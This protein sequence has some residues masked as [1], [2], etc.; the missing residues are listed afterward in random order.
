MN[1]VV[2]ANIR[3][4]TGDDD[5]HKFFLVARSA[6]T[7]PYTITVSN[8]K[9]DISVSGSVKVN[10]FDLSFWEDDPCYFKA[11]AYINGVDNDSTSVRTKFRE[12]TWN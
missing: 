10:D 6:S 4:G 11:G 12:L 7:T 5:V 9:L 2:I 3:S 1:D 8:N